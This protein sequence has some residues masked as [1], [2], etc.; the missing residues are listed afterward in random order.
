ME[1]LKLLIGIFQIQNGF[2]KKLIRNIKLEELE[3]KF[4]YEGNN[5]SWRKWY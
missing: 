3:I 5:L 1:L 2:Q 4:S